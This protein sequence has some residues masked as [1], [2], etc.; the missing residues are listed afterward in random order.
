MGLLEY[1]KKRSFSKSP[2]PTGG[3][4]KDTKLHFV[5]QK[6][7]AS[8]L[9]YDFRLEMDGVLKSWAIPKG[10]SLNPADKRLA[11]LVEDHPY[12]Y[13]NF[14]GI[15]PEGNYGAGTVIV[16][17]E[18][19]YEPLENVKG[20]NE[21]EKILRK[22]FYSGSL[23]FRLHGKKLQG[24][25]VLVKTPSRAENAW[26]LIKHRDEYASGENI[27]EEDKSV[28]SGKTLDELSM[29]AN[30]EQ[31]TSNRSSGGKSKGKSTAKTVVKKKSADKKRRARSAAAKRSRKTA[32]GK[33]S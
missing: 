31:W 21:Q 33:N 3:K 22:G 5:V 27:S 7:A 8:R 2:E 11:M 14:E 6:H 9:H 25:F 32:R 19:A 13:R 18:G 28:I 23:K 17:D 12:D 4:S 16:W 26:L 10:P 24:E 20:K 29:D 15:I 1:K 30:A